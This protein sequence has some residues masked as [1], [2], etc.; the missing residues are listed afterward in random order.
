M[1]QEKGADSR[2][3]IADRQRT[4]VLRLSHALISQQAYH[5][6]FGSAVVHYLAALGIQTGTALLD[7]SVAGV[8]ET[9]SF[10]AQQASYLVDGSYSPMS[11]ILSLLAYAKFVSHRTQGRIAGSMWWSADRQTYFLKGRSI[12]LQLFCEMAL[13][14]VAEAERLL[15]EEL[16][17]EELLWIGDGEQR[18]STVPSDRGRRLAVLPGRLL[19]AFG[20]PA[21]SR[22]IDAGT[23]GYYAW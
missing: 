21:G 1:D 12:Q 6:P 16:L 14:I 22:E 23:T 13:R 8:A 3:Y 4:Y 10:L 2:R 20:S 5:H 17:W 11:E 15:W 7:A 19:P 9:H 18:L